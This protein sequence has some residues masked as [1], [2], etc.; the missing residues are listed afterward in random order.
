MGKDTQTRS[1]VGAKRA[2][3]REEGG[4][5]A[6]SYLSVAGLPR[7][8]DVLEYTG[9]LALGGRLI[10]SAKRMPNSK[11]LCSLCVCTD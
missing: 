10:R 2:F 7:L 6:G 9:N 1:V 3:C 5:G 8:T 11:M 4:A